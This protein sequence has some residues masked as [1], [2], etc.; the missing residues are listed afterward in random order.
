MDIDIIFN[1]IRST[2]SFFLCLVGRTCS[3]FDKKLHSPLKKL[4]LPYNETFE[5]KHSFGIWEKIA[6]LLETKRD[7]TT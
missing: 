5:G 3:T 4:S 6:Q 1:Q 2:H 7:T